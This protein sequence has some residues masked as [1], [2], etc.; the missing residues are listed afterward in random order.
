MSHKKKRQPAKQQHYWT[1]DGVKFEGDPS[2]TDAE[3]QSAQSGGITIPTAPA[4]PR[5]STENPKELVQYIV[6]SY[7]ASRNPFSSHAGLSAEEVSAVMHRLGFLA[8]AGGLLHTKVSGE[9]TH[10]IT[11]ETVKTPAMIPKDAVRELFTN[12]F[13]QHLPIAQRAFASG[14]ASGQQATARLSSSLESIK[15]DMSHEQLAKA[16]YAIGTASR[17]LGGSDRTIPMYKIAAGV[18]EKATHLDEAAQNHIIRY[19][20]SHALNTPAGLTDLTALTH[21]TNDPIAQKIITD[22]LERGAQNKP[23]LSRRQIQSIEQRPPAPKDQNPVTRAAIAMQTAGAALN[24]FDP[25]QPDAAQ[26]LST[27]AHQFGKAAR[28]R[29]PDGNLIGNKPLSESQIYT[30]VEKGVYAEIAK[31]MKMDV[32]N[33]AFD[34]AKEK[35]EVEAFDHFI[36]TSNKKIAEHLQQNGAK[37]TLSL[38]NPDD[39]PVEQKRVAAQAFIEGMAI[40]P[41]LQEIKEHTPLGLFK[42]AL[43]SEELIADPEHR[44][45]ALASLEAGLNGRPLQQPL[46]TTNAL[47]LTAA[48]QR[49]IETLRALEIVNDG[50]AN[51]KEAATLLGAKASKHVSKAGLSTHYSKA[52]AQEALAA[53]SEHLKDKKIDSTE[54]KEMDTIRTKLAMVLQGKAVDVKTIPAGEHPDIQTQLKRAKA[55]AETVLAQNR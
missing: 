4:K 11:Q 16:A 15:P 25:S 40:K 37:F 47:K 54:L 7:A 31:T 28:T 39:I 53:V 38:G 41:K 29:M 35:I 30:L 26:T 20:R 1:A 9:Y 49:Y 21:Y 8:A 12:T 14:A 19:I 6:D 10:P 34:R 52:L 55:T 45:L 36:N 24:A 18:K 3:R 32:S 17:P 43:A 2:L 33:L 23:P 42:A 27:L 5:L 46:A 50:I 51:D 22:S 48:Q 44:K 13:A